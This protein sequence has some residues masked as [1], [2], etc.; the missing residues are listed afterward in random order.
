M[1][2]DGSAELQARSS[3]PD[4]GGLLARQML[5]RPGTQR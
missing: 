4:I 5:W 3:R 2:P 1:G